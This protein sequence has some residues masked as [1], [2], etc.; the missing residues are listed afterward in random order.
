MRKKHESIWPNDSEKKEQLKEQEKK[1]IVNLTV[2]KERE[3]CSQGEEMRYRGKGDFGT[4]FDY[5]VKWIFY[6][7]VM[8][9][10][11][12]RQ[13]SIDGKVMQYAL[14][15]SLVAKKMF[16]IVNYTIWDI[17]LARLLLALLSLST[18][19]NM[20]Q[21]MGKSNRSRQIF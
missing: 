10:T 17:F 18:K 21:G 19:C 12:G 9:M 6:Y 16:L 7:P 8:S 15:L 11:G 14:S 20:A 13:A 5:V 3:K 4:R 2:G 1:C